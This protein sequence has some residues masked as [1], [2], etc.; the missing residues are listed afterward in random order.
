M[1]ARTQVRAVFLERAISQCV[2]GHQ[3]TYFNFAGGGP[4]AGYFSCSAKK[5][6]Q[7][8][9]APVRRP[10]RKFPPLLVVPG[11]CHPG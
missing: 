11:G 3:S 1:T 2:V 10:L 6:N 8:K 9:A 5:S 4:A 7:K